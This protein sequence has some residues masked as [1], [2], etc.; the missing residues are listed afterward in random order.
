MQS[1]SRIMGF[2]G[3]YHMLTI[4]LDAQMQ[5]ATTQMEEEEE[6]VPAAESFAS[7]V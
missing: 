3:P 7:G 5:L 2:A 1:L 4:S 6:G